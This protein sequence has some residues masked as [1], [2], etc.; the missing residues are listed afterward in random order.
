M[1][2]EPLA[3]SLDAA[4]LKGRQGLRR[5]VQ[6]GGYS[7]AGL[8]AAYVGEAAFRQVVLLN[9]L[10]IPLAFLLDVSRVERAVL[11]AVVLLAPIVEL[12]NS[13]IEATVDRISLELHPLSKRAKDMGSAAQLLTM[14]LIAVVWAV[15]L[16]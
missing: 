9:L 14:T 2:T 12:L 13:A 8:R 4:T 6:A 11:I 3:E 5:I 1:D 7:L 10:L 16:L 15:I